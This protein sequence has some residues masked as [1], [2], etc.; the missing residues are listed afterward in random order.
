MERE[1]HVAAVVEHRIQHHSDT[2]GMAL[3]DHLPCQLL[4]AEMGVDLAVVGCVVLVVAG[5][6]EYRGQVQTVGPERRYVIKVIDDALKIAACERVSAWCGIP[7]AGARRIIGLVAVAEP[8]HKHLIYHGVLRPRG[9]VVGPVVSPPQVGEV[10]SEVPGFSAVGRLVHAVLPEVEQ[11]FTRVEDEVVLESTVF[12]RH[13][14]DVVIEL[15][16]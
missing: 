10:E 8:L 11:P 15:I 1:E 3:V 16:A 14:A 9:R 5:R 6:L 13:P 4:I 2:A 7:I 12:Q